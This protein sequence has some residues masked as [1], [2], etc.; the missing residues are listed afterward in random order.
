MEKVVQRCSQVPQ[1]PCKSDGKQV[2]EMLKV[3]PPKV[4]IT[5]SSSFK[6]LVQELTGNGR[7]AAASPPP[8][9][10]QEK[11]H[12]HV[13]I[14]SP[15]EHGKPEVCRLE[16][17]ESSGGTA[18]SDNSQASAIP[19]WTPLLAFTAL[20]TGWI[21]QQTDEFQCQGINA[22]SMEIDQFPFCDG[23]GLPDD[24]IFS[25]QYDLSELSDIL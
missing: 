4:Y 21:N 8:P 24:D 20:Q 25:Y 11:L 19:V 10:T 14:I 6:R 2:D 16:G 23:H 12:Y 7:H 9:R 5:D 18:V 3:V 15:K 22:W 17:P 1:R 13:P